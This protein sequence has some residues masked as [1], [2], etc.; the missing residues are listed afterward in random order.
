MAHLPINQDEFSLI[1]LEE[2]REVLE[3]PLLR[4]CLNHMQQLK[5][6]TTLLS[7]SV[8]VSDR[9]RIENLITLGFQE[10]SVL[11]PVDKCSLS[12]LFSEAK[13]PEGFYIRSVEGEHESGLLA[14]VHKRAFGHDW[15]S[16]DYLKVMQ[17]PGFDIQRELVVLAPDGRFA[18]FLIYWL[19]PITKS[20]LFEPVGC[21]QD[22]WRR[23]LTKALMAEGLR[24][25]K[26]AGMKTALVGYNANNE[27]ARKLY[28]S[29]GFKLQCEYMMYS[30]DR[31]AK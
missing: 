17:T 11:G 21:H 26:K 5:S 1:V 12:E 18:A 3:L 27:A 20:G 19:D 22:F 30:K 8:A 7:I 25:M 13:L 15:K 9:K 6:R 28:A 24:R 10:D 16:Q 14:E 31:S 2:A 4:E 29:V 23:G